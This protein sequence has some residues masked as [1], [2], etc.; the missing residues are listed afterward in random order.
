SRIVRKIEELLSELDKGVE[1]L[2]VA[3]EQL[4]AYRLSMLKHA[5]EGKLTAEWRMEHGQQD[6]KWSRERL[7]H[8][9]TV[10]G[11]LTKNPKRNSLPL[12]MKY[13]RVAN[14]YADRLELDDISEIGVSQEEYENVALREGDLLVVEGNGSV[15]QIGRVAKWGGQLREVGHQNHL[16]RV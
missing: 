4:T 12:R 1:S 6:A 3:R 14:V 13:L 16:I 10:S 15:E 2:I 11:G 9:A 7:D 8:I 5:F